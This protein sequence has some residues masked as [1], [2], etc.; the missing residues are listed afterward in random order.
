M[1][2][3]LRRTWDVV[4][5]VV[6][7]DPKEGYLDGIYVTGAK[8]E[9]QTVRVRHR[10]L[11]ADLVQSV[12]DD[13]RSSRSGEDGVDVPLHGYSSGEIPTYY[14]GLDDLEVLDG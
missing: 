8:K 3:F 10:G 11:A 1:V 9:R 14:A 7:G 13:I 6:G 2:E 12:L 4:V 5:A